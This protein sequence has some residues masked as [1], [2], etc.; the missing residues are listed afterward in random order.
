MQNTVIHY[1]VPFSC[2]RAE[3]DSNGMVTPLSAMNHPTLSDKNG[4][5]R[6]LPGGENI[7]QITAGEYTQLA[8][9]YLGNRPPLHA[10]VQITS[11]KSR[12]NVRCHL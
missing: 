11:A 2:D 3:G 7:T 9:M 1:A 10:A 8:Y 12:L 4:T 6:L 5:T